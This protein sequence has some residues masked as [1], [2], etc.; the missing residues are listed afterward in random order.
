[1][2]EK[3]SDKLS[4]VSLLDLFRT[5]VETQAAIITDGLILLEREPAATYRLEELMRGAHS[6]K[7]AARIVNR[8]SAVRVA[9]SMED[10]F[11]AAQR[12][13]AGLHQQQ[14]DLLL[15]GVDLLTRVATVSD[16]EIGAWDAEHAAEIGEIISSLSAP[17]K[18]RIEKLPASPVQ[19]APIK[20]PPSS[21]GKQDSE[22]PKT[23]ES[24]SG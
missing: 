15:R 11:V 19:S 20:A 18:K 23:A 2:T 12:D 21:A 24:Y 4:D 8:E 22:P 6:L 16:A 17:V 7:G 5:E 10:C 13:N 9:H 1:M 3:T 14:I